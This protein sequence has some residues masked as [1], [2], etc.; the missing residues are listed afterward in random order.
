MEK[1]PDSMS[2]PDLWTRLKQARIVQVLLVY[3]GVCWGILQGVDVLQSTLAL[4]EWVGPVA[5]ILL[6]IGL[7]IILATAWVQSLPSTDAREAAGEVPTDWQIA[8]GDLRRSLASGKLP[9]LNW[10]RAILGG[11]VAL[12]LLFG[13]SGLFVLITGGRPSVG[14]PEAGASAAADGIAVVPF[15]VRGSDLEIWREGMMDL[16]TNNLDGVGGYRTIDSR[17]VMSRWRR[18]VG[19]DPAPDLDQALRAAGSTGARYAL[20]GSVVGLGENVRLVANI[21]DLATGEEV[22]QGTAEGPSSE[23]LTLADDL[24]VET[25]RALLQATGREGGDITAETMTTSSLPALRAFLEGESHYRRGEFAEAVQGYEL[26]VDADST[27]A[28]A[29]IRLSEAYG[30]LES[31]SSERMQEVGDLAMAQM[32]RLSPRYQFMMESWNALNHGNASGVEVL[33]EA[34]QKYPDDPEAWFLLAETYIH[35]EDG[36]YSD[37]DAIVDALDRAVELDPDFA[38]YLIH[39]I[40]EAVI[41]GE[42]D[43]ARET[44]AR[45][46]KLTGHT[47]GLEHVDF[48]MQIYYGTE[49]EAREAAARLQ[50]EEPQVTPIL[51]GTFGT[52][53]DQFD[54]TALLDP[55]IEAATGG[56]R[57]PF[58]VFTA[59]SYGALEKANRYLD[60]L[61]ITG[62]N[63]GIQFGH[64]NEL[65]GVVPAGESAARFTPDLCEDPT[66]NAN[67]HLFLGAAFAREEMWDSHQEVLDRLRGVTAGRRADDPE[68]DVDFLEAATQFLTAYKTLI[69]GNYRE[70]RSGLWE[71]RIRGDLVGARARL[72]LGEMEA[73][74]GRIEEAIRHFRSSQRGFHRPRAVLELARLNE[75]A[76]RPGEARKYWERFLTIT[77]SGDPELP[78]VVE[79]REALNRLSNQ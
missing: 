28:I 2:K 37:S 76:G 9:H 25:M 51:H 16:L 53:M 38:P 52:K 15:D 24:A 79:A 48:A 8:P 54:R 10:G 64:A 21:Y 41:R 77:R 55:A 62:V 67:C 50:R 42:L 75:A 4:P 44:M 13:A 19:E 32:D 30:W 45:Y 61:S 71:L 60:S 56:N 68:A 72:A 36:T 11:G 29:L 35:I 49:E 40:E 65:W 27:F 17:T 39:V 33:L 78:Q 73:A 58:R 34:V 70:A 59:T 1:H 3:L 26:A 20:S 63:V 43:R 23:V 31:V 6:L 22:A 18:T 74:Q 66:F 57:D 47:R 5:V 7:I 14:P 12:S 46:E 69:Q